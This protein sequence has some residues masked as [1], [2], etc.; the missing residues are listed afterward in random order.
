ML[1]AS[2]L[3]LL[4]LG[5]GAAAD[6][7][8]YSSGALAAGWENWSWSSTIDFASTDGP[9]GEPSISVAS[10][11][12][13]ALS[14]Y[15]ESVFGGNFAGIKF[16][17]SGAKPDVSLYLNANADNGQSVSIPFSAMNAFIS[18]SN[19]TTLVLDFHNLPPSGSVL[20]T[21]TCGCRFFRFFLMKYSSRPRPGDRINFQAGGNG[22]TYFI[23]NIQLLTGM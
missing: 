5:L 4:A 2:L 19:W 1:S 13:A 11:A 7:A 20:P 18:S 23:K 9:G 14:L 16:D 21:D 3:S 17:V 8:I 12:Y 15:D 22:A 6:Q 10:Q